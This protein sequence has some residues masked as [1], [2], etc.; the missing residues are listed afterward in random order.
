MTESQSGS[1]SP[2]AHGEREQDGL[3]VA[4][5][6]P[7]HADVGYAV[8]IVP[9]RIWVRGFSDIISALVVIL[10]CLG[11]VERNCNLSPLEPRGAGN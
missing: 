7:D 3:Q 8:K 10:Y 1:S 4:H 5:S 2:V 11:V 9:I 6:E